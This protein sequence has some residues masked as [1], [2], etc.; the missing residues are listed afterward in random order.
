VL[1]IAPL[2]DGLRVG[3]VLAVGPLLD[4]D[5]AFGGDRGTHVLASQDGHGALTVVGAVGPSDT[6]AIDR[7][8][9]DRLATFLDA[10]PEVTSRRDRT[11]A[12][13]PSA[14]YFVVRP[15]PLAEAVTGL[16]GA[17]MTLAFGLAEEVV[18]DVLGGD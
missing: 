13:H 1:R 15:A 9:L 7:T 16:G 2:P 14:P 10:V 12:V 5:R 3:P 17:E 11:S 4:R 6:S 8:I 18:N